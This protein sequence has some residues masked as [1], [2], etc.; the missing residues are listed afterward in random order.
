[1]GH[2][3]NDD[4]TLQTNIVTNNIQDAHEN[5]VHPCDT[6]LKV[7]YLELRRSVNTPLNNRE[8]PNEGEEDPLNEHRS[9]A[10]ATC[11]L[12]IIPD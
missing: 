10:S 1:M 2:N 4:T 5:A 12:S 8:P 9:P 6:D 7:N 11:P 3:E